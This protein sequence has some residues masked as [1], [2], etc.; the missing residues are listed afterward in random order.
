ML[1]VNRGFVRTLW[2]VYGK[3]KRLKHRIG[4]DDHFQCLKLNP[5]EQPFTALVFGEDNYKQL[6]DMG[7]NC[8][9]VD[10]RPVVWDM[11]KEQFRHKLEALKLGTQLHDEIVYLDWDTQPTK[12]LPN[13]FW[14]VLGRKEPIQASLRQYFQPRVSWRHEDRRKAPC[15]AFIYIRDKQIPEDL[16]RIW[17]E[18]GRPW[19]EE[20]VLMKYIDNRMGGWKGVDEYWQKFEPEFFHLGGGCQVYPEE[21]TGAKK[22]C[23]DHFTRRMIVKT[24]KKHHIKTTESDISPEEVEAAKMAR[25]AARNKRRERRVKLSEK[26]RMYKSAQNRI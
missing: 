8:Q 2:G 12:P 14:D 1:Q 4:L 11:N 13:D 25:I 10:K 7:F 20:M 17:E 16:I 24:L 21:V 22:K 18:L 5:Y 3:E 23:F 26:P 15:A 6:V 9:I 19:T